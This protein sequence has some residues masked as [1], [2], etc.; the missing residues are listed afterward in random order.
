MFLFRRLQKLHVLG[1]SYDNR[2]QS[3]HLLAE[4]GYLLPQEGYLIPQSV[5]YCPGRLQDVR[6]DVMDAAICSLDATV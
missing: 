2:V 6:R 3:G 5:L 4:E 1:Q